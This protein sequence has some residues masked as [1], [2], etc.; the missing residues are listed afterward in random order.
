M[1]VIFMLFLQL[2]CLSFGGPA[3]HIGY[4]RRAFVAQR[5]WLD[6]EAF[7][8]LLALCQF[9]PGPASSQ[10][11]FAIGYH[12]AGLKGAIAAFA[13]FTLPSFVLMWLVAIA[14]QHWAGVDWVQGML[15]GLKLLAVIVVADAVWGM[16]RQ[17]CPT[18]LPLALALSAAAIQWWAPG[19]GSQLLTLIAAALLGRILLPPATPHSA[20][21]EKQGVRLSRLPLLLFLAL[22]VLLPWLASASP[23]LMLTSQFYQAGSWVFGGGHVVLP[24]LQQLVGHTL[25]NDQFLTGYAAAQAMPGP[26]FTLASFLGASLIPAH[27]IL[28]ALLATLAIF[29][30][31]FLLLL[32]VLPGWQHLRQRPVLQQA[33]AGVN[34]AVSGLLLAALYQPVFSSAVQQ[35]GDLAWIVLG[36]FA[37]RQLKLPLLAVIAAMM[38]VGMAF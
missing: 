38:L 13:G 18:A 23:W 19:I 32:A 11:G 15:H 2:G 1:R 36:W 26:L 21:T 24:L 22:L 28:A 8:S 10:L 3:A 25:S 34:A 30:P 17:F 27:S 31:G 4:F 7:S 35:P 6:D 29:L 5:Q 12:R 16:L 37:L 33:L 9:L 14:G 20:S